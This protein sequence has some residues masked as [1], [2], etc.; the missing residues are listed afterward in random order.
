[1]RWPDITAILY[2]RAGDREAAVK[3]LDDIC[4]LHAM[5][6]TAQIDR[7]PNSWWSSIDA[8]PLPEVPW[9]FRCFAD[10]EV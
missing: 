10:N 2:P 5:D 7:T 3:R 1:M 9:H 8:D 4:S 6:F